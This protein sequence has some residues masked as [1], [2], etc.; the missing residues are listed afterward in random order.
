MFRRIPFRLFHRF[1]VCRVIDGLQP[2]AASAFAGDFH[3]E[4]L[5]PA[6]GSRAVPVFHPGRYIHGVAGLHPD[7]GLAPFL[8]IPFA[9]GADQD[10]AAS[11]R[12]MVDV[13]VFSF[14]FYIN[15]LP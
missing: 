6:V 14:E 2:F 3:R 13:P 1:G 4:M 9:S 15:V 11:L 5:E 10:L 7:G 8:I 12:C